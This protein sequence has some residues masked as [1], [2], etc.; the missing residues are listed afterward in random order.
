MYGFGLETS[1]SEGN[2]YEFSNIK[3]EGMYLRTKRD[4]SFR[5]KK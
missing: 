1:F 2:E 3:L 4:K 5:R